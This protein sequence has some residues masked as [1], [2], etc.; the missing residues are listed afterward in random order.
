M[1][2]TT[3]NGRV[4]LLGAVFCA[5]DQGSISPARAVE[6]FVPR[7]SFGISAVFHAEAIA[8]ADFYLDGTADLAVTPRHANRLGRT[9]SHSRSPRRHIEVSGVDSPSRCRP[10]DKRGAE[11]AKGDL[12]SRLACSPPL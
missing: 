6:L 7:V 1:C 8:S 3:H 12:I 5:L 2:L 10:L 4:S 11:G 9:Q